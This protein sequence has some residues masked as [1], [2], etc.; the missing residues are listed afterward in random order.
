MTGINLE[1]LSKLTSEKLGKQVSFTTIEKIGSGYHSDGFKVTTNTGESFFVK[2]FHS[3]DLGL[4]FPERKIASLLISN[5]MSNRA[6]NHPATLGVIVSNEGELAILPEVKETTEVYHLQEFEGAESTSYKSILE[7]N[8]G[9]KV[10][11][12]EDRKQLN[13][14]ADT[15]VKIHSTKHP[16]G[17]SHH[18]V[19]MYNDGIRNVLTNSEL[20]MMFLAKCPNDYE[21]LDIDSQK[22]M[23]SLMYENI[24]HWMCRSDRLVAL[25]GDFWGSN[26]FFRKDGSCWVID[27][28]RIPWGDPAIDVGWFI[29]QYLFYYHSTGNPYFR[30]LT[31]T[32]ISIYE[33]KSGDKELRKA[34]PLALGW[35]GIIS[36]SPDAYPNLD[37]A[38]GKR[39]IAHIKKILKQKEF[40]WED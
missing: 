22:E 2:H 14:I 20:S 4:E 33:E 18:Q 1:S 37:V 16:T 32:W 7:K 12:D 25:H 8:I 28:S 13:T 19:A 39:F 21:I 40:V 35:S 30:E 29:S 26:I 24:K 11:D 17:D 15:L 10:V 36:V 6:K 3:H 27:F 31:E 38:M 23:I 34:L 9:K 5:G